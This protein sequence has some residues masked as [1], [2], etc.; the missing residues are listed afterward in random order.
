MAHWA[1]SNWSSADEYECSGTP[2]VTGTNGSIDLGQTVQR[3][4][5][6]RV[7]RWVQIWNHT[8]TISHGMKVGF[9]ANG[10][11]GTAGHCSGSTNG[12]P[13]S[14]YIYVAGNTSTMSTTGRLELRCTELY[15]AASSANRVNFTVLAGLTNIP[16]KNMFKM[17][18]SM[19][20][21]AEPQILGVG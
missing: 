15:V 12:P 19:G 18:G 5:F 8:A 11:K 16:A 13:E 1:S 6:P 2:Y 10:I 4:T 20:D 9:S 21:P 3:I 14:H 7:T 17:T